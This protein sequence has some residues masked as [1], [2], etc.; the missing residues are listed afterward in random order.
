MRAV[1]KD[2]VVLLMYHCV[3]PIISLLNKIIC[4]VLKQLAIEKYAVHLSGFIP[5]EKVD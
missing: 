2:Y 5:W 4:L 3:A 1:M